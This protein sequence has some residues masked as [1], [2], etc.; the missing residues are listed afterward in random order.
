MNSNFNF[1]TEL[2][3]YFLGVN[4]TPKTKTPE[5]K[6]GYFLDTDK[7]ETEKIYCLKCNELC[8]ACDS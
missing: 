2:F 6:A 3:E 1:D 4:R 8:T 5:C 7:L